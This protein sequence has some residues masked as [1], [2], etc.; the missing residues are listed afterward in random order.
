MTSTGL[1]TAAAAGSTSRS[2]AWVAGVGAIIFRPSSSAA[3]AAMIPGPPALVMIATRLP[4][5]NGWV[6]KAMA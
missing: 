5:G 1:P 3:S 4:S 6:A 2:L